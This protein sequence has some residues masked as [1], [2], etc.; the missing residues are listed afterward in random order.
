MVI[1]VKHLPSQGKRNFREI[2]TDFHLEEKNSIERKKRPVEVYFK[3]LYLVP[4]QVE[5]QAF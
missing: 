2:S 4:L 3:A 1:P 5:K